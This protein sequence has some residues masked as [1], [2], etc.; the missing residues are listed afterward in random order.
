MKLIAVIPNAVVSITSKATRAVRT[1]TTNE[2]GLYSA[3]AL[4][5]GE[6]EVRAEAEGSCTTVHSAIV[7][8][9]G[10]ITVKLVMTSGASKEVVAIAPFAHS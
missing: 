5:S 6:Y 10:T 2:A 4:T 7:Q 1:V 3:P 8:A 9:G